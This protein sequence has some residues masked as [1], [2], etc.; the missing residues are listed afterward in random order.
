VVPNA[1]PRAEELPGDPAPGVPEEMVQLDVEEA[2]AAVGESHDRL[3]AMLEEQLRA[4]D[5]PQQPSG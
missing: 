3:L 2:L 4:G 5:L 1:D